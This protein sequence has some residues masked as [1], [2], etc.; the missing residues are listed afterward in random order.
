MQ[1]QA[2]IGAILD[3]LPMII[4]MLKMVDSTLH[5]DLAKN[6]GWLYQP[7]LFVYN[8]AAPMLGAKAITS[9]D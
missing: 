3:F 9:T 4:N 7:F 5:L 1:V 6:F 8:M 2:G